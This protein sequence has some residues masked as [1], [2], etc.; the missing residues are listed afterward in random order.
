MHRGIDILATLGLQKRLPIVKVWLHLRVEYTCTIT[1]KTLQ[2]SKWKLAE[3]DTCGACY[4]IGMLGIV[5]RTW[6]RLAVWL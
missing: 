3:R 2:P 4:T 1:S 5:W 6:A